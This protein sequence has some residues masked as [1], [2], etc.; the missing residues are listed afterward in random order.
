MRVMILLTEYYALGSVQKCLA[1]R[2]Q[3]LENIGRINTIQTIALLRQDR[4]LRR[5]LV[6]QVDLLS[7]RLH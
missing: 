2:L 1:K 3:E 4:M 6:T 5:V 7:L